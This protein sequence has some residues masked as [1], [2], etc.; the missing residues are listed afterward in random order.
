MGF[1]SHARCLEEG[2]GLSDR[3]VEWHGEKISIAR[4]SVVTIGVF[5]GVHRGHRA[6]IG[7]VLSSAERLRLPAVCVTFYPSPE[8]VLSGARPEYLLPLD[9]RVRVM[10][11][12][13][14]DLVVVT[15]FDAAVA[16]MTG[17]EFMQKLQAALQPVE[18]WVG[19]DFALGRGRDADADVLAQ[20]GADLGYALRVMPRVAAS[21]CVVS[22]SLIRRLV[23]EGRVGQA[24]QCLG[25]PYTVSGKVV[26]GA[27]RGRLLGFPTANL[28]VPEEKLLPGV[29]VYCA[30]A[31]AGD[32]TW[33][34][35]VNVGSC[36]TFH[37]TE[38]SVEAHLL[39]FRGEL[40]DQILEVAFVSRIRDERQ[41]EGA[42]A[43]AEQVQL[44]I[45]EAKRRLGSSALAG[46]AENGFSASRAHS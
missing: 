35:V 28:R 17:R 36:P 19:E 16:R 34:A 45:A 41:F 25:R 43:L 26:K 20:I 13:G 38:I 24:A 31:R 29:G 6:L 9:E 4:G 2:R 22:S 5:D 37:G 39:G 44:D 7:G 21:G 8:V 32:G 33:P 46:V 18:V 40:H 11:D 1:G 30:T 10:H 15:R 27:G 14:V 42:E 23:K 3:A 12:L